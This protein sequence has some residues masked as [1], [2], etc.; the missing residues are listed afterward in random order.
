MYFGDSDTMTVLEA[1]RSLFLQTD[2][3]SGEAKV[4]HRVALF[5]AHGEITSIISQMDV[6]RWLVTNE[7]HIGEDG[8]KTIDELG[9]LTG[10]PPVMSVSPVEP[11][12]MAFDKMAQ[13]NYTGAPVLAD[14]GELIA[15][16]SVSDLRALTSEHFGVLSLPVAEFLALEHNT[17]Y[18]GYAAHDGAADNKNQHHPFFGSTQRSG[19]NGKDL[20]LHTAYR[21]TTLLQALHIFCDNHVHRVY[22]VEKRDGGKLHVEAVL[23]LTDVLRVLA[24]VW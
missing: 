21:T 22:I 5:N 9:L 10:K 19:G 11:T 24:G 6:A 15:N 20:Q 2:L 17:S 13:S 12:L 23:T 16:L 8:S 4:A 18:I 1:I 7:H 3:T 14:D